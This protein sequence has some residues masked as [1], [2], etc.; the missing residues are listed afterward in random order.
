MDKRWVNKFNF[1]R[2]GS[3]KE[4]KLVSAAYNTKSKSHPRRV[5]KTKCRSCGSMVPHARRETG[6]VRILGC[7]RPETEKLWLEQR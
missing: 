5:E 7:L 2:G 6:N 4:Q 1:E 3:N